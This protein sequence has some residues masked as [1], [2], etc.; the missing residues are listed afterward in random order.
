MNED[1]AALELFRKACGLS[2]PLALECAE[3]S[4]ALTLTAGTTRAFDSPFVL[5][6]RDPRSDLFLNDGEVSQR[7]ALL[8]AI[9]GRVFVTD[10]KSRAKIYWEGEEAP[11]S[12]GWFDPNQFI[13]VGPYRIR[14]TGFDPSEHQHDAQPDPFLPLDTECVDA[15][16]LPRAAL[17]L[18]IRVGDG[19]SLWPMEGRLALVGRFGDCQLVLSDDSISTFHAAL[20]Q[21]P[22][23]VW[24]VD[25]MTREGV[26]VN[27][28]PVRWAWLG[29]GDALRLGRF[30]F[31][32]RYETPPLSISRQ[33]VPLEAGARRAG[34]PGTELAVRGGQPDS[35]RSA[36]AVRSGSRSLAELNPVPTP[37]SVEPT[38]LVPSG[39]AVWEPASTYAPNPMA[40]WQQQMQL[41]ESFHR[42]MIL[43]VQMFAAMHREQLASVRF[44]LDRVQQLTRKLSALQSKLGQQPGSEHAGGTAD[45][46]QPSQEHGPIPATD[47]KKRDRKPASEEPRHASNRTEPKSPRPAGGPDVV[48]PKTRSTQGSVPPGSDG[49]SDQDPAQIH[50]FLTERIAKLQRERQGYWERIL[51]ALNN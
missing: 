27:G 28:V 22:S 37:P 47:R 20:V 8:F 32:L 10:L 46:G 17:E 1:A 9:A 25:L 23:G 24:V 45:L 43:M 13:Q 21:T 12:R 41:M 14:W 34:H 16:P 42:D 7:H 50:A 39:G 31:I 3:A 5:V 33:D 40:M 4:R 30:T 44:E 19:S 26:Y 11:R 35:A 18:P 51:S 6:G 48:S 36:L 38:A 49:T 15:G 29:D 2:T